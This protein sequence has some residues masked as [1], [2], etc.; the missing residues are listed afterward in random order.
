[1][2]CSTVR[3][4]QGSYNEY[5]DRKA[6]EYDCSTVRDFKEATTRCEHKISG[7]LIVAL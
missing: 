6:P 1:M 3:E 4:F 2:D 7:Y 5:N